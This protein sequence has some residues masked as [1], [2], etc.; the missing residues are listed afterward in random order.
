MS[1]AAPIL[2]AR[3]L[4]K[5]FPVKRGVLARTV[6]MV[7]AVDG[8]NF[9]IAPGRTLGLVGESGCGKTTTA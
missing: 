8:V 7:R 9:S 4:T 2:E 1:A 6:G 3:N 5:H